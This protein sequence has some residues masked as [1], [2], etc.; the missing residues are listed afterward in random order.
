MESEVKAKIILKIVKAMIEKVDS[1]GIELFP[2]DKIERQNFIGDL[3]VSF[4]V[5]VIIQMSALDA[6]ESNHKSM[7][8]K[9][10][11]IFE[12]ARKFMQ[13]GENEQCH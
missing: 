1:F 7:I 12:E 6:L 2:D 4:A 10:N 11:F 8:S 13:K 9:V 5:N 3:S